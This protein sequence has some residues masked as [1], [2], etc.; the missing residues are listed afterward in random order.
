MKIASIVGA[1]P[2]FIKAGPVSAELRKQHTEILVHTGQHYDAEMSQIFFE[3]MHIPKPKYNL[4]VGSASHSVQTAKILEG[5][6]PV[7]QKEMPDLVLV[8]GDTNSTLAGALAAAKLQIRLAHVEAGMRSY[9]KKMPEE[10]NRIVADHLSDILFC[11]TVTAVDNLKKENIL[12][13][14]HLV[15]DVMIDV[16]KQNLDIAERKSFIMKKL[17]LKEKG[18]LLATVHRQENTDNIKNLTAIFEA[19]IESNEYIVLPLH[20]RTEKALIAAQLLDKVRG[21]NIDIIRPVGYLD[22]L[23][24]EKNA[25]KIIT[26][27]GGVQKEAYFFKVPCITLRKETEWVETVD[28]GWNTLVT[29]KKRIIAAIKT[30][31]PEGK[32]REFYGKGDAAKRI[33]EAIR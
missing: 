16:L 23:L 22:M 33:A 10:I 14:V 19:F 25:K 2:Q 11:S 21:R 32:Q 12:E 27:S 4:G 26:D 7:L 20:P 6:E 1:R 9:N 3:Q 13:N 8:Y 24:L 5:L 15:G 30:F 28:D 31:S 29:D 18:Y 17:G